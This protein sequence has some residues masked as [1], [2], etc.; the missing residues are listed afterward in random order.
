[1]ANETLELITLR[2]PTGTRQKLNALAFTRG[3]TPSEFLIELLETKLL[4]TP[5]P[6]SMVVKQVVDKPSAHV[7]RSNGLGLWCI[8]CGG[9]LR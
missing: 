1:M 5:L 2:C 4:D 8:T 7:C 3:K 9:S 6:A